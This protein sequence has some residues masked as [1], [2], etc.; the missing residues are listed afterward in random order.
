[1]SICSTQFII[2]EQFYFE[3]GGTTSCFHN[4]VVTISLL[5]TLG[6][7][8]QFNENCSWQTAFPAAETKTLDTFAK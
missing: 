1:M 5:S 6:K 8:E 4:W 3:I 7:L 2:I